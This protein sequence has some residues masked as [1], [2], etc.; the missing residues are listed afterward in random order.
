MKS[1]EEIRASIEKAY[2]NNAYVKNQAMYN[3]T[4]SISILADLSKFTDLQNGK[5]IEKSND[6]E[7][8][9]VLECL[10]K[11]ID[12]FPPLPYKDGKRYHTVRDITYLSSCDAG[13]SD[14]MEFYEMS[15][16][17]KG[18][19][20]KHFAKS[21]LITKKDALNGFLFYL[22]W[23]APKVFF[24]VRNYYKLWYTNAIEEDAENEDTRI[25]LERLVD[26]RLWQISTYQSAKKFPGWEAGILNLWYLLLQYC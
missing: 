8:P 19:I 6:M 24:E 26:I 5:Y 14:S 23:S 15:D 20:V 9:Y 7:D 3:M 4:K 25:V 12:P 18:E 2:A 11:E 17:R 1:F 10:K 22:Y 16:E 13:F 21:A